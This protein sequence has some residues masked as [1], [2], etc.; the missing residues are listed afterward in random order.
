MRRALEGSLSEEVAAL[1]RMKLAAHFKKNR[2][3]EKAISLWQEMTPLTRLTSYRELAIY[4]EHK[5]RDYEK[6]RLAAEEGLTAAA[7]ASRSV[8]RDFSHRLERIRHKL[9]SEKKRKGA[10]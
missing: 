10:G 4:Y 8:E 3:W 1:A 6:A 7:G 2:D 9:D 5:E